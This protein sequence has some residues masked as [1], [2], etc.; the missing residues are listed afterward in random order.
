MSRNLITSSLLI[1]GMS[2]FAA[3]ITRATDSIMPY[4]YSALAFGIKHFVR[5]FNVP[6]P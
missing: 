5:S 4:R 1:A 6:S 2:F 3:G